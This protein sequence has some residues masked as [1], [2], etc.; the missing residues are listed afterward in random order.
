MPALR[1][2]A[3]IARGARRRFSPIAL[4]GQ[5]VA[6]MAAT[7]RSRAALARLTDAQLKDIGITRHQAW[8]E[9]NRPFW[10]L[11]ERHRW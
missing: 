8:S 6:R 1:S 10:E 7:R 9:T 5:I 3:V 4:V 11:P 2:S